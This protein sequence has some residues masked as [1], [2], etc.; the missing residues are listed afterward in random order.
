M[1]NKVEYGRRS[2]QDPEWQKTKAEVDKRDHGRCSFSACLSMKEAYK[3]QKGSEMHIDHAHVFSA[4]NRPDLIY[5]PDNVV[6]LT[7]YIHR[8]MD[9]FKNPL[10]DE[11]IDLNEHYYWWTRILQKKYYE[12]DASVDY[13]ELLLRLVIAPSQ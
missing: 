3:L 9:N 10:T 1:A 6:C 2:S 12:Y 11:D 7:R 5:N 8:R 4:S 13:E